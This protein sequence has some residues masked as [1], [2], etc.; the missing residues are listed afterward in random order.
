MTIFGRILGLCGRDERSAKNTQIPTR[1]RA[2]NF[3]IENSREYLIHNALHGPHRALEIRIAHKNFN[4]VPGQCMIFTG[5]ACERGVR[6]KG[7]WRIGK[8]ILC[9]SS[10]RLSC[11]R[12]V[13]MSLSMIYPAFRAGEAYQSRA[14]SQA[15][16][17]ALLQRFKR[18]FSFHG[19]YFA[20]ITAPY[21]PPKPRALLGG[22]CADY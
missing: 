11:Q 2:L 9:N 1:S 13:C 19:D 17:T 16:K 5:F 8:K 4:H 18:G 6:A 7:Y 20:I 3:D 14:T 22:G 21:P 12:A 10:A 15:E